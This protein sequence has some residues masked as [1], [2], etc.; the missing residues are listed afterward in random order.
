MTS[1]SVSGV[2]L[3]K[4]AFLVGHTWM[5]GSSLPCI[6]PSGIEGDEPHGKTLF[7]ILKFSQSVWDGKRS[8]RR[9]TQRCPKL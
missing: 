8:P 5:G 7:E 4:T 3:R 1:C 2:G 6:C 9:F